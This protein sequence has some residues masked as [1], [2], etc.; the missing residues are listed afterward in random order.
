MN[1]ATHAGGGDARHRPHA[2]ARIPRS[3]VVLAGG[4]VATW[5]ASAS[6]AGERGPRRPFRYVWGKAH[7]ILP[8]THSDESGY[9]SLCEG[10]NGKIYVGTAKYGQNAYLVEFDPATERQRV[11]LDTHKVCGLSARG[12]AAQAKIHTRNHVGLSGRIYVGS[13]RGYRTKGDTSK[14]AG[15]Y[16]M[17]YDPRTQAAEN[18]GMPR[19]GQGVIDVVADERRGLIYVVTCEDQHWMLYDVR[20]R[21]YRELGPRLT[22]YATTL[23]DADGRANA[24]T[25]DFR[26]AQ[27]DPATN[28]LTL[29][30]IRIATAGRTFRRTGREAVP[31]WTLTADRR[32]AWLILMNDPTLLE[33][34]LVAKVAKSQVVRAISHGKM[35]EGK[36]PDS[37]CALS[38]G[39]DGRLYAVVR[40]D[41]DTK[42][43]RGYLHHLGRFDPKR[44]KMEDLG[45][46][47]VRNS[48][49]FDFEKGPNGERPPWSHGYHRLPDGVLTPLHHHLAMIVARDGTVYV[50]ILYPFTL[51]RIA[52]PNSSRARRPQDGRP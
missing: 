7:H 46:L 45:V 43:G 10:R 47:A 27:F 30:E 51:L 32:R 12:Y 14:Y 22:P 9:F 3:I 50:T 52:P 37:R 24:L 19:G 33:I 49:F 35:I 38:V 29:R 31:T 48:G 39:P 18:L 5:A 23:I 28:K 15:G 44:R 16:V 8:E 2:K 13:K 36:R 42:F 25:D 21:T 4:V 17:T 26:L 34:D 40:V 1:R 6:V 11:V 20:T 41:N